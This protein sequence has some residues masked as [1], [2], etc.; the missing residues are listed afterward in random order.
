MAGPDP[1]PQLPQATTDSDPAACT[2]RPQRHS[3]RVVD[4]G[5]GAGE[6][7]IRVL[8][9]FGHRS[10]MD[11][12]K[13]IVK[14]PCTLSSRLVLVLGRR[15]VPAPA[16]PPRSAGTTPSQPPCHPTSSTPT[17]SRSE[18]DAS[19]GAPAPRAPHPQRRKPTPAPHAPRQG[20]STAHAAPHAA[21]TTAPASHSEAAPR[22]TTDQTNGSHQA[23]ERSR[24]HHHTSNR[25][26]HQP[27]VKQSDTNRSV[28]MPQPP[29]RQ[30]A[31]T[32]TSNHN[33]PTAHALNNREQGGG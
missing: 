9:V 1:V 23:D 6:P 17:P 21:V 10:M 15:P 7:Q 8:D 25:C 26:A 2:T 18:H 30:P 31:S 14:S 22:T 12:T 29:S 28:A 20:T 33:K 11:P 13:P 16:T 27:T 24:P 4:E 32:T 3:T 5:G 19:A